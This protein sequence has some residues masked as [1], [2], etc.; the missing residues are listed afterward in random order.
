ML[1]KLI[2]TRRASGNRKVHHCTVCQQE[3]TYWP[4]VG[5]PGLPVVPWGSE[6]GSLRTRTQ[7]R[8]EHYIL[9]EDAKPVAV[10]RG[11]KE[12]FDLFDISECEQRLPTAEQVA[13]TERREAT[14]RERYGCRFCTYRYLKRAAQRFTDGMC[15][16]CHG[17][18]IAWNALVTLAQDLVR[19]DVPILVLVTDPADR[20]MNASFGSR[21]P[22]VGYQ[23]HRMVTGECYDE[24]ALREVED[25]AALY[26]L[27][28]LQR[29][30]GVAQPMFVLPSDRDR[31]LFWREMTDRFGPEMYDITK[32]PSGSLTA[33]FPTHQSLPLFPGQAEKGWRKF[34]DA[35]YEPQER[36]FA[37]T[38]ALLGLG[39]E[40]RPVG[41]MLRD[42]LQEMAGRDLIKIERLAVVDSSQF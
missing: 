34:P 24:R 19:W 27:L 23:M 15:W 6:H 42:I 13:R 20:W 25:Y 5:C 29:L 4:R 37:E 22:I 32:W 12:Y 16:E 40:Q 10:L 2:E 30:C 14:I 17:K 35:M 38:C 39:S 28:D 3:W 36:Y 21:C 33:V 1:H 31:W 26:A 9:P 18:V 41:T 11:E 8:K 7:A